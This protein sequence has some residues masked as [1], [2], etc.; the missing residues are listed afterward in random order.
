MA[1]CDL[2]RL[3]SP[4][5]IWVFNTPNGL[6]SVNSLTHS[7]IDKVNEPGA[8]FEPIGLSRTPRYVTNEDYQEIQTILGK[9]T[10]SVIIKDNR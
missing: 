9:D 8:Y 2:G 7:K 1:I 3:K 6:K 10:Y 5:T 4:L